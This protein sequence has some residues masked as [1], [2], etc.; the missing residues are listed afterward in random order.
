MAEK[1][2]RT[3]FTL[4]PA[5]RNDL[6][7]ISQRSKI[8]RS[9]LV[10]ALLGPALHD[11]REFMFMLPPRASRKDVLKAHARANELMATRLRALRDRQ[12]EL[13]G[14]DYDPDL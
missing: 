10:A 3:S 11:L 1:M 14:A 12:D 8:S 13:L 7:Y 5:V 9:A 4:P 6:G 2:T